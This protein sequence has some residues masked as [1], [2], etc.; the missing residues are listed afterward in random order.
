MNW[1][2]IKYLFQIPVSWFRKI[3]DRVFKAYG[4]NF[5]VVKSNG[6]DGGMHIDVDYDAFQRDVNDAVDGVVRSVDG[7]APDDSGDV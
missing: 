1:D 4:T 5:I 7:L 2:N 6:E 3:H